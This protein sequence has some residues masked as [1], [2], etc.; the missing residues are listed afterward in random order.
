ME[1]NKSLIAYLPNGNE[2]KV[3]T[4]FFGDDWR[5]VDDII[6]H[7]PDQV[8]VVTHD[9][10]NRNEELICGI[11]FIYEEWPAKKK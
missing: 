2:R 7:S 8:L 11:P 5:E 3:T 9:M 4:T 10:G 6:V 1:K